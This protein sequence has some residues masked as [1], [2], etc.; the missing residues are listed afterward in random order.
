MCFT[1]MC[2]TTVG[3]LTSSENKQVGVL[4]L[5]S[6]TLNFF[7]VLLKAQSPHL[8]SRLE[9]DVPHSPGK[10]DMAVQNTR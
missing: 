10:P 9:G 3:T 7:E 4:C 2:A 5:A 8:F 6:I 1:A